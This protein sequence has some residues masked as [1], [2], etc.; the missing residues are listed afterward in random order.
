MRQAPRT[1]RALPQHDAVVVSLGQPPEPFEWLPGRRRSVPA[2]VCELG[3]RH[4]VAAIRG[5]DAPRIIIVSAFGVGDTRDT[6]PWYI[7]LYL[8]LFMGELMAD[9]DRQEALIKATD[10]DYL[11]VQPVALTD[12]PATGSWSADPQGRVGKMQVSR[13]DLA[14]FIVRELREHRFHRATVAFSGTRN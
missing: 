10:L 2:T 13:S 6:A 3:T 4:I 12:G 11:I 5:D 14:D 9:K 8:R 1:W 7:R